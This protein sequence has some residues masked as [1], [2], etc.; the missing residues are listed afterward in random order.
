MALNDIKVPK[1]NASGTFDEVVLTP[2]QIGAVSTSD[3]RLTD[4]RTPSGTLAHAA[5]HLAGTAAS[6]T[7][8]GDNETFSEEVTITANTAGTAGNSITLTFDGVDDVDT[9][10][11][12]WNAA[13]PSNQATL[14]IGDGT[15]VPDNGDELTLSGGISGGSDPFANINQDLGT[16]NNPTFAGLELNSPNNG[17]VLRIEGNGSGDVGFAI[18][19]NT[20]SKANSFYFNQNNDYIGIGVGASR[21]YIQSSQPVDVGAELA[22]AGPIDI[23]GASA[24]THKATTRTN[25]GA[26]ASGSITSSGLTQATARIL[27]RTSASTGAIEEIQIGS[28]L[29]LSAGELSATGSGGVSAIGASAADILSVSGS[30]IVADDLGADRIYG[31]DD[32]E[33]KAIGYSLSGI[34]T[35]GSTLRAARVDSYTANDTWNKP[36]GA[37]MVHF[38]LIAGGGGG[39]SGRR[40]AAGTTRCGGGGG[41]GG[42][43]HV[44][45]VDAGQLGNT[46]TVTVGAGGAG[47]ANAANDTNG[48]AG[49]NGGD[50]Y[51]GTR[52]AFRGNGG[53]GGTDAAGGAAGAEPANANFFY[54]VFGQLNGGGVGSNGTAV[55]GGA[56]TRSAFAPT[57]AG[58]GGAL[59][60]SNTSISAGTAASLGND[61]VGGI[62]AGGNG[63]FGGGG[64][65]GGDGNRSYWYVGTGGGGSRP[66]QTGGFVSGAGGNGALYGAG[67]GG[68]SGVAN[69]TGD[70]KGGNGADGIVVITTYF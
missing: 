62:I 22:V 20:G 15:Q 18:Y 9:V 45:W 56:N 27:G 63:S 25:L 14:G 65:N 26:A 5:S 13:N 1:E 3:S 19:N 46:E 33:N 43:I 17:E 68:G 8:I 39:G 49:A 53:G 40:G 44:G 28:G 10:L 31:W 47:G 34:V 60:S 64:G 30:D 21:N 7:G 52:R 35:D 61:N 51:F 67:G 58:G 57:G 2:A 69:G 4:S 36:A 37:K 70:N 11:A 66:I 24:S 23:T 16:T 29:S 41:S 12:A 42:G 54:N 48:A 32:S 55:G 6:Y 50:S 38:L 59:N